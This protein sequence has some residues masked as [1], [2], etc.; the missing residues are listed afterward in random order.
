MIPVSMS[1]GGGVQSTAI[2][3][4][5]EQG[6]L[7]APDSWVFADTGDE[8]QV[9]YDHV[10]RWRQRIPIDI[11]QGTKSG[12]LIRDYIDGV[13]AGENPPQPPLWIDDPDKPGSRM[14][15]RRQ[16]TERYKIRVIKRYLRERFEIRLGG[17]PQVTQWI[18]I[19][20]DEAARMKPAQ[21]GW[22][23][24]EW[25]LIDLGLRRTDCLRLL[26]E[27]GESAPRSA[28]RYCPYHGNDEW[29]RLK[30]DPSEWA[31][32]V[33]DEREIHA[34]YDEAGGVISG[35]T[36]R[37]TLHRSGV[38]IGEIDFDAQPSLFHWGNDCSGVCGV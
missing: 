22:Y 17:G 30:A 21:A 33:E 8:P 29:R 3:L 36:S 2:A 13:R 32:I 35:Q 26:A 38:P 19:S 31:R 37:P 16:C 14:P 34:A 12:S 1:F 10:E 27:A 15:M 5:V 11:V 25:P 28:C 18:G 20:T 9:V 7:P 4:L 24:I 23:A 6:R